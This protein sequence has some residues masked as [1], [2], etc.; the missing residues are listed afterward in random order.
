MK[1]YPRHLNSKQDYLNMLE[2][3]KEETI[4]RLKGLL[5]ERF[6]WF[7]GHKLA[8]GETGIEDDTHKV[9]STNEEREHREGIELVEVHYQCTLEENKHATLFR[10]GFTVAEI[11]K[12]IK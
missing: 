5:E 1:G 9:I 4:R 11:E 3:D 2:I 12:L 8:A 10:L 6:I 7:V